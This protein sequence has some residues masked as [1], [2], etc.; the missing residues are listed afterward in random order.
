VERALQTP[1]VI[2]DRGPLPSIV[3]RLSEDQG[4]PVEI[5]PGSV[6]AAEFAYIQPRWGLQTLRTFLRRVSR[7][8]G[9]V[10]G[11]DADWVVIMSKERAEKIYW[12]WNYPISDLWGLDA[13]RLIEAIR[14]LIA[15]DSWESAGTKASISASPADAPTSLVVTQTCSAHW[16]LD[17]LFRLLRRFPEGSNG[18]AIGLSDESVKTADALQK[19]T[20]FDFIETPL[21]DVADYVADYQHCSY[22]VDGRVYATGPITIRSGRWDPLASVLTVL[23]EGIGLT[24]LVD[25]GCLVITTPKFASEQKLVRAYWVGQLYEHG[26]AGDVDSAW[27]VQAVTTCV[28]PK[29][30]RQPEKWFQ[31]GGWG[32]AVPLQI[33][34][35]SPR[36]PRFTLL[37]VVQTYAAQ[38]E[39]ARLLGEV[40]SRSAQSAMSHTMAVRDF[41]RRA[42]AGS[43]RSTLNKV[44]DEREFVETPLY[45][46][47]EFL[48]DCCF[49]IRDT[50]S[51][52]TYRNSTIYLDWPAL[53]EAGVDVA[54]PITVDLRNAT[55]RSALRLVLRP[56][57]LTYVVRDGLLFVTTPERANRHVAR[58]YPVAD[59]VEGEGGER[60]DVGQLARLV[61]ALAARLQ[62]DEDPGA[63]LARPEGLR[64]LLVVR[65]TDR[66]HETMDDMMY[67]L[68]I[69]NAMAKG[70]KR[71]EDKSPESR[72]RAA[73]NAPTDLEFTNA[74]LADVVE[75]LK[76]RLDIPIVFDPWPPAVGGIDRE[77]SVTI[78]RKGIPLRD[79]LR[80]MLKQPNLAFLVADE[81]LQ[82]T[83]PEIAA[84]RRWTE[85]Y[86][87][88]AAAEKRI[89]G[90]REKVEGTVLIPLGKYKALVV[91]SNYEQHEKVVQ[92]LG[93]PI[94]RE[95]FAY[96][97]KEPAPEPKK[98]SPG[99]GGAAPDPFA[100]LKKEPPRPAAPAPPGAVPDPFAPSASPKKASP[101][102]TAPAPP[103]GAPDPF[104]PPSSPKK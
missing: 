7:E 8:W 86:R 76:K 69:I 58:V 43:M 27:F 15:P 60:C 17:Q 74:R 70:E 95:P 31:T 104:A 32:T 77:A 93:P 63:V 16:Q 89:A 64:A 57:D 6:D 14:A 40:K 66:L 5:D 44:L 56:F 87:V 55:V 9:L 53:R 21:L 23:L 12:T 83:T 1:I 94:S 52:R 39:I 68:R 34:E 81:V 85:V 37:L 67:A 51:S 36:S 3:E 47:L 75:S 28:A 72:I 82:I 38:E 62:P 29:S 13:P 65:Q 98:A 100:G 91:T 54:A 24:Y 99:P 33:G 78:S 49:E 80:D 90:L 61:E 2:D 101:P 11:V 96:F 22:V 18:L 30:W 73:L 46:V 88:D 20:P 19:S 45:D 25:D 92:E 4:I 97:P 35:R 48:A 26:C 103:R 10:Y 79:G 41:A 84:E 42:S 59:L 71:P 102:P 50:R